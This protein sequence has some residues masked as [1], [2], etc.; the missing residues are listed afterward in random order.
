M[1]KIETAYPYKLKQEREIKMKRELYVRVKK[2]PENNYLI[3][4]DKFLKEDLKSEHEYE[5]NIL[6]KWGYEDKIRDIEDFEKDF[7]LINVEYD[8]RKKEITDEDIFMTMNKSE[9]VERKGESMFGGFYLAT[10]KLNS[11]YTIKN[12]R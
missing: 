12:A 3:V 1:L 5:N 7:L 8:G 4:D 6:I 10:D 9:L 11:Q 2:S